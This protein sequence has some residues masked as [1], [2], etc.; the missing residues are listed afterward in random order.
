MRPGRLLKA[1]HDATS[2]IRLPCLL[3]RLRVVAMACYM[4][5]SAC[6]WSCA[7][8]IAWLS[9]DHSADSAAEVFFED[10]P[11]LE[12]LSL[13]VDGHEGDGPIVNRFARVSGEYPL[14]RRLSADEDHSWAEKM[15]SHPLSDGSRC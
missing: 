1:D 11:E 13:H 4:P 7:D 10:N 15:V 14:S 5:R 8:W 9:V 12:Y 2:Q 6:Q 3:R